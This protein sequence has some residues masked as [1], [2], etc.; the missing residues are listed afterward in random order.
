MSLLLLFVGYGTGSGPVV[1]PD[2]IFIS[3]EAICVARVVSEAVIGQTVSGEAV[4]VARV[5]NESI[6]TAEG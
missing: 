4:L 1:G 2:Q 3:H 6:V 5:V